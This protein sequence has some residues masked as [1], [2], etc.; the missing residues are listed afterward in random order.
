MLEYF[1][2]N[3]VQDRVEYQVNDFMFRWKKLERLV[4]KEGQDGLLI[5][6]GLD[7]KESK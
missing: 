4:S 3:K 2:K 6:T 5:I 7:G 1:A